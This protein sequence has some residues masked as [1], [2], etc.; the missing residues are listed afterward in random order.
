[1]RLGQADLADRQHAA[2]AADESCRGQQ[3]D[4]RVM[5]ADG[6]GHP[7]ARDA[8]HQIDAGHEAMHIVEPRRCL[9]L[10]ENHLQRA[11]ENGDGA[12]QKQADLDDTLAEQH[13]LGGWHGNIPLVKCATAMPR[14]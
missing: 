8:G 9:G 14:R 3:E 6:G 11:A 12:H 7:Q 13:R 10:A 1:M 2:E 4:Q 5:G